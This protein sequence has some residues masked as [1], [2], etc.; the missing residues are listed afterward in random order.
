MCGIAGNFN[1]KAPPAVSLRLLERMI[2]PL[3]HRGPDGFGF[4][5]NEKIGLAH[6]RWSIIDLEG[7]W[8]P[9]CNEDKS[10]WVIF[11]GEIFNY[12]ELREQLVRQGHR[13]AISSDTEV[14]V[15][16]YEE[17]GA[18]FVKELNGQFALALYDIRKQSLLLAHD[19]MGIRPLFYCLH[20]GRC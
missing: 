12:I 7:G 11:N 17:N 1:L 9:I 2:W 13:F 3:R 4:F 18:D 19:R 10:I 16:L 20:R 6:A 5:Q 14:L 8:Q 15:H